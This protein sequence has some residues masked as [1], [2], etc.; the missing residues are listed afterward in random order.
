MSIGQF[1]LSYWWIV[2]LLVV[3][4]AVIMRSLIKLVISVVVVVVL[5]G[6]FWQI[7]IAKGFSESTKCFTDETGKQAIIFDRAQ[8]MSPGEERN[9]FIC[10]EDVVSFKRLTQCFNK[11]KQNNSLSFSIY[12]RLPK[13][14]KII[15]ETITTHNKLC[16]ELPL[17]SPSF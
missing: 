4:I 13:F 9:Q 11:S 1:L 5:F 12:S 2:I 10:Q 3:V 7:F 14:R 8:S 15:N 6:L 16:P 17:I